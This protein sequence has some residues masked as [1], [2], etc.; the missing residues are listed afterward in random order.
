MSTDQPNVCAIYLDNQLDCGQLMAY[1]ISDDFRPVIESVMA[2]QNGNI[3]KPQAD[4]PQIGPIYNY[5][6]HQIVPDNPAV[7]KHVITHEDE[8][9]IHD[10]ALFP[11]YYPTSRNKDKFATAIHQMVLPKDLRPTLVSEYHESIAGRGHQGF[12]RVYE[13]VKQRY[14]W[15]RI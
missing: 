7:A 3:T 13:A 9:G 14:Y 10:N 1:P 12:E 8:Y 5:I 6:E 15:P 4:C 2:I 11:V